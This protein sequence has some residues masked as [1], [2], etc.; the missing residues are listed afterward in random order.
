MRFLSCLIFLILAGCAGKETVVGGKRD[1]DLTIAYQS[2]RWGTLEPC[3][4]Q[5]KPYGGI[6]R[7]SNAL[8][9]IR[10]ERGTVFY[11]DAGNSLVSEGAAKKP[12]AYEKRAKALVDMLGVN[13]LDALLPGP[14]EYS[15]GMERLKRLSAGSKF[16]W[17]ATNVT[18]KKKET[19]PTSLVVTKN[20]FR[21]GILGV[22]SPKAPLGGGL[23]IESPKAAITRHLAEI[24]GK[25]DFV[26]LLSNMSI[27][28][29]EQLASEFPDIGVVVGADAAFS[30]ETPLWIHGKTLVVDTH[31]Q[32]YLL[33]RL[34]IDLKLPL[35]G[36]YS[37]PIIE[38]NRKQLEAWEGQIKKNLENKIAV[39]MVRRMKAED[40][41][42]VIEG[43]SEYHNQLVSLDGV[44]FGEKNSVSDMIKKEKERISREARN[45]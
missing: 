29:N 42:N 26:V 40:P 5:T 41:L 14:Y 37:R 39:E 16:G 18:D 11:F 35:K 6:D 9:K 44:R 32:G 25:S 17:V 38:K 20:N 19:F 31:V 27:G 22:V 36:F 1:V 23:E 28:E 4:C 30:D 45:E 21:I 7:E 24:K 33:G 3:G 15:L 2:Q 12:E 13:G 8:K 43:G 34:D 10:T